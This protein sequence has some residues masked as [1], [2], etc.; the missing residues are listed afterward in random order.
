MCTSRYAFQDRWFQT[1]LN[2]LLQKELILRDVEGEALGK[3]MVSG[4]PL[5]G[6][7]MI[8]SPARSQ[9]SPPSEAKDV[10][11]CFWFSCQSHIA[12]FEP[13]AVSFLPSSDEPLPTALLKPEALQD[14]ESASDLRR[15]RG[16]CSRSGLHIRSSFSLRAVP[17]CNARWA[18]QMERSCGRAQADSCFA[19]ISLECDL[20]GVRYLVLGP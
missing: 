10:C 18:E 8:L 14:D 1:M 16:Q 2:Q 9:T 15:P 6:S 4:F 5:R 12:E 19:I 3:V 20:R 17:C 13:S 7:Q 11:L